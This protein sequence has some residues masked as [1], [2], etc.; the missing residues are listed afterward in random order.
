MPGRLF[1]QKIAGEK[2]LRTAADEIFAKDKAKG[3]DNPGGYPT[4]STQ[5]FTNNCAVAAIKS[6]SERAERKLFLSAF[7]RFYLPFKIKV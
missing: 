2:L 5:Y 6:L 3:S 7:F 4:P 1:E